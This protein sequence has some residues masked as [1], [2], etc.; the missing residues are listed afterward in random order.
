[1]AT[2]LQAKAVIEAED[3]T[4]PAFAAISA[5]MDAIA[6]K[7]AGSSPAVDKIAGKGIS[8]AA[9][10]VDVDA[11]I[12]R[13]TKN[14]AL[15]SAGIAGVAGAA[16]AA[17]AAIH[18]AAGRIHEVQRMVSSG[19]TPEEIKATTEK[20]AALHTQMPS[21]GTTEMM[22][23]I[24]NARG[25]VGS[26]EEAIHVADDTSRLKLITQA[27]H[28]GM[29][30]TEEMHKLLKG[31]EIEGGTQ[32]PAKFHRMMNGIAKGLNAFGDTL[33]PYQYYE[34]FKYGRQ[35]TP[36]LSEEFMMS[37]APSLAQ[38]LGGSSYGKAIASF[39]AELIGGKMDH[40]AF[41]QLVDLGLIDKKDV[42]FTKTGEAKGFKP[43]GHVKGWRLA[44]ENPYQW[45]KE[46]L[47]KAMDKHGITS[48]ADQLAM[49]PRVFSNTIGAQLVG[50]MLTQQPRIEKDRAMWRNA[51][52]LE[53]ADRLSKQ[54]PTVVW[55][56]LKNSLDSLGGSL[57]TGL[58]R[59]FSQPI[60]SFSQAVAKFDESVLKS[61]SVW[62]AVSKLLFDL[63][64]KRKEREESETW[65]GPRSRDVYAR[66]RG[67]YSPVVNYNTVQRLNP[68]LGIQTSGLALPRITNPWYDTQ[69]RYMAGPSIPSLDHRQNV[70]AELK[71]AAEI[72]ITAEIVAAE[73]WIVGK[74]KEVVSTMGNLRADT[75][76]SMPEASPSAWA[77]GGAGF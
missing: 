65:N 69:G 75:G 70:I 47:Q 68:Q 67:D 38:S 43:G 1:M 57:F 33:R 2:V 61:A 51:Q 17:A 73:E 25:I 54:D 9:G 52:G 12:L 66:M 64:G 26:T 63:W 77:G 40:R 62:D 39:N 42:D 27:A 8:G 10:S 50:E 34:M 59:D 29:D 49:V 14:L 4:G 23:M 48:K 28:P 20:A 41:R 31:I 21:L 35:A 18:S 30:A 72:K 45:T 11:A 76:R 6:K 53:A 56:G 74:I 37:T 19:M 3:K 5:K 16:E 7:A 60:F 46:Y 71:G 36:G 15:F 58:V 24:R 44:Q 22:D 55:Q 13:A 32:D